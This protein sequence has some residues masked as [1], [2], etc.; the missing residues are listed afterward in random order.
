MDIRLFVFLLAG[1]YLAD[2]GLQSRYV[3]EKKALAFIEAEG[4]YALTAHAAIH[5]LVAG[6][7]THHFWVMLLVAA[8]HWLIDFGKAS[9]LL[10]DKYPHTKGA[11]KHGQKTGLYGINIDQAL[12]IIVLLIVSAVV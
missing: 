5:G 4:F 8:T 7:I 10:S 2:Y 12:H 11:R 1:H 6:L 3:A 9:A